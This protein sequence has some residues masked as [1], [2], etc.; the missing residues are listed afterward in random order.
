MSHCSYI[1]LSEVVV[2][3]DEVSKNIFGEIASC[4]VTTN[5]FFVLPKDS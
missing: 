4:P 1:A 3:V 5:A 2:F